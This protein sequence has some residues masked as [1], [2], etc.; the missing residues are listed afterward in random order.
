MVAAVATSTP[1]DEVRGG[2]RPYDSAIRRQQA[3]ETR[4]RVIAA[5]SELVHELP[6][7]DWHELTFRAVAERAGVGERTVY[8]HFPS[9]R[10]LRDAVMQRLEA[11][12]G[13]RYDEVT[14]DDV[15]AV[16]ALVFESLHGFAVQA[17]T[18]Q[19]DDPTFDDADTRRQAALRRS[20]AASAPHWTDAQQETAAALL[21]VLWNLPSYERLINGW[22][23]DGNRAI[24]ALQWLIGVVI[25]TV[26]ADEPPP[27][28][29]PR[30]RR[31]S[32]RP[33]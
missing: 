17:V 7:W 13:V 26:E 16:A 18:R 14:L 15:P 22:Q 23:F 31:R 33:G 2:R 32:P 4:D 8:R 27:P 20:V 29:A 5:G 1:G 3:A 30:R 25:A 11:E 12:A 9:E 24:E 10:H 6:S 28:T 21:D 19:P